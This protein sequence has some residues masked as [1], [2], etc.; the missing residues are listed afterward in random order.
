[1]T[2]RT[3][4]AFLWA[5]NS[6]NGYPFSD[7]EALKKNMVDFNMMDTNGDGTIL[8]TPGNLTILDDPYS[9]FYPGYVLTDKVMTMPIGL[10]SVY[11]TT[12]LHGLGKTTKF[13][14]RERWKQLSPVRPDGVTT[15]STPCSAVQDR[16]FQKGVR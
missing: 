2:D 9:P 1:M 10:G 3:K 4:Y 13:L 12:E 5:P 7:G 8:I 16:L 14:S 11:M 6:G 15:T